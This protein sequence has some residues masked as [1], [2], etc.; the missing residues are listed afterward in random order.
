MVLVETPVHYSWL[1][2]ATFH[3]FSEAVFALKRDLVPGAIPSGTPNCG[4]R[5]RQWS[6]VNRRTLLGLDW[7][8]IRE[9]RPYGSIDSIPQGGCRRLPRFR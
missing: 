9:K 4:C 7:R 3:M 2:S 5:I 6:R 8:L 1:V